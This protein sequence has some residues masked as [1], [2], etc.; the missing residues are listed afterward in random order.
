M[1]CFPEDPLVDELEVAILFLQ[2][3]DFKKRPLQ[4]LLCNIALHTIMITI[5]AITI[6]VPKAIFDIK[7]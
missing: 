5:M 2:H 6:K 4:Q 7:M 3:N 1:D